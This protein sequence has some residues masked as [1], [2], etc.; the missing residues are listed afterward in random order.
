MSK[1]KQI[2]EFYSKGVNK[3]EIARLTKLPRN[4][5][6]SY[7]RQYIALERPVEDLL[8][9]PNAD[10]ELLFRGTDRKEPDPRLV[11]LYDFFPEVEKALKKKGITQHMM[12]LAYK[13]KHPDGVMHTQFGE[14]FRRWSKR[15]GST[16]RLPHKAGDKLYVDYAGDTLKI[17]DPAT[18]EQIKAEV[19]VG[20]LPASQLTYVEATFTQRKE[21]F[22]TSCENALHYF[23]GVPLA[24]VTDNLKSAVTKS[25]RYEPT[26]N[27]SFLD[28]VG[29]YQMAALPAAPY[30]PRYKAL[31]E[32]A[33]K[34]IYQ[35]IYP[36]LYG[37]VFHSLE[38]LNAEIWKA[39]EDHNNRLFKGRPYSRRE[40]FEETELQSLRPLVAYRY[41]MKTKRFATVTRDKYVCLG[42]DKHYYNVPVDYIGKRVSLLYSSDRV[43]I[44]YRYDHIASHK[45]DRTPFGFTVDE[46]LLE[47][48][49]KFLLERTPE[50]FLQRAREVG[51]D[52]Y[53]YILK[54]LSARQH[55]EQLFK[56]CQGILGFVKKVGN[57]RLNAACRRAITYEDY[58][59]KTIFA[60]LKSGLDRFP[61][62]EDEA[63]QGMP[64]HG[65]I[66]GNEYYA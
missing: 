16:T 21:D 51:D 63:E 45:R 13:E 8:S 32:G 1:A 58:S 47:G 60:I 15:L 43:D 50:V 27:E 42:E 48:K 37:K 6:K 26:L 33:V 24:I 25:D 36:R 12:W 4:T 61:A 53:E 39:L 20:I 10:L 57:D 52:T 66:R 11:D 40:L 35:T 59:Y 23:K 46:S 64:L 30:K 9:M 38:E 34:L 55:P 62:E 49:D 3:S 31:V 19:F 28:F 22:I 5:V 41:E 54:I 17:I 44:Y 29:H 65:N 14:H 7:I 18:G 2:L 56:S